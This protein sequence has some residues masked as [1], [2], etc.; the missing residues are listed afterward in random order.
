MGNRYQAALTDLVQRHM[1][2]LGPNI[3]LDKAR[4]VAGLVLADDGSVS[5]LT[6]D[7]KLVFKAVLDEYLS[8]AGPVAE[9]LASA[10]LKSHPDVTLP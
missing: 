6:G 8:L 1:V 10:I 7:P 9:R 4:K 3:A 5:E 2:V